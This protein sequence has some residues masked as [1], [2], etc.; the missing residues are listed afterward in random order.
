LTNSNTGTVHVTIDI[1]DTE[2]LSVLLGA[3]RNA[4]L[5]ADWTPGNE[6]AARIIRNLKHS[7]ENQMSYPFSDPEPTDS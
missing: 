6:R 1:D 5:E 4:A 3:L 2:T 7:V